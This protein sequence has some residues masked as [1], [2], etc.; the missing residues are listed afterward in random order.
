MAGLIGAVVGL[1]LLSVFLWMRMRRLKK[2]I[3]SF[4]DLLETCLDEMILGQKLEEPGAPGDFLWDKIYGKLEQVYRIQQRQNAQSAAE[5][6]QMKELISDISHQT[7]TP[8][9]NMKLYL[10]IMKQEAGGEERQKEFLQKMEGQ[11][12]KLDFLLQS[13]VKMSRLET[14]VIEIRQRPDYLKPTLGRAVAAVVPKAEKKNIRLSVECGDALQVS[15]DR[16]W[17]EEAL[18]NILDNGV[19]YTPEGGT[20]DVFVS[21]QEFFVKISIRDSGKGIAAGRQAAVFQRFYR[22][23]EVHDQ[24]GIGVGLYL[25]RKI[26]TLQ[27]GYIQVQSQEGQGADFQVYLPYDREKSQFRETFQL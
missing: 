1:A 16:K 25:A 11:T 14:G 21:A 26:I 15:H 18:F 13:M 3:Y 2:E 12:E 9:A 19:K 17:T 4:S 10:D 5:K 20:I 8:I 27:R 23:P 7:K 6:E 24:E 22:E